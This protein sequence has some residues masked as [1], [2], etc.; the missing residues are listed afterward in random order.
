MKVAGW[1]RREL[2]KFKGQTQIEYLSNCSEFHD[3]GGSG[4]V[5]LAGGV[6]AFVG[7]LM[8]G[9]RIGRFSKDGKVCSMI[10]IL[11]NTNIKT[12]LRALIPLYLA[13]LCLLLAWEL[14]FSFLGSLLLME[15]LR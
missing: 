6:S 15:D 7:A 12:I 14:L 1:Q 11:I 9:P 8:L 2:F 5:H 10:Y 13:I 3:F 4:V